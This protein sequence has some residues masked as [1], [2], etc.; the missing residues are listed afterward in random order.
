MANK[1][2]TR[3]LLCGQGHLHLQTVDETFV[4]ETDE[5][6]VK[7]TAKEVPVDVCDYCGERFRGPEAAVIRNQ[8]VAQAL[9]LLSAEDIQRLRKRRGYSLSQFAALTGID[10]DLLSGW[11]KGRM[12]PSPA[13]DKYLRLLSEPKVFATLKD[14]NGKKRPFRQAKLPA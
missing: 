1:R 12:L 10:K 14:L 13:F 11:E 8:A 2:K 5:E 6:R 4:Y 3:C 9:H 7:V